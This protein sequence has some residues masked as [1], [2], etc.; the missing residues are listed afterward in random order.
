MRR[1]FFITD[2]SSGLGRLLPLIQRLQRTDKREGI[3]Y[4]EA[5]NARL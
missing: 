1:N 4:E 3:A 2:A 5:K